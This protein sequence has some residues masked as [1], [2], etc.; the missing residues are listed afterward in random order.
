LVVFPFLVGLLGDFRLLE[1]LQDVVEVGRERRPQQPLHVLDQDELRTDLPDGSYHLG[2]KI[3][4]VFFSTVL[5]PQG[6]GLA[7]GA[8]GEEINLVL[9]LTEIELGD[10]GFVERPITDKRM[11]ELLVSADGLASVRIS[12]HDRQMLESGLGHAESEASGAREK[13]DGGQLSR[14][15]VIFS[16]SVLRDFSPVS[17]SHTIRYSHPASFRRACCRASR[18]TFSENFVSQKVRLDFGVLVRGHL[19]ECRCQKQP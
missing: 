14:K 5:A 10:I 18:S 19:S 11:P 16:V 9:E 7:R 17:H 15:A 6:E 2:E 1:S 4:L 12:L 8:S 13:L 3:A